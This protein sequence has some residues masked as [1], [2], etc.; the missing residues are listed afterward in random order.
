[1]TPSATNGLDSLDVRL[2]DV[3]PEAVVASAT[4]TGS[5]SGT[6][7]VRLRGR[8]LRTA[9]GDAQLDRAPPVRYGSY[10][11]RDL[12]VRAVMTRSVVRSTLHGTL[13]PWKVA[14]TATLSPFDTT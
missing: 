4:D 8:S 12:A 9:D 13:R 3:K 6:L 14:A 11:V 2:E 1:M 5:V 7:A 10:T